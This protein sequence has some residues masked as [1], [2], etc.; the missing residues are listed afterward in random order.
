VNVLRPFGTSL[1]AIVCEKD[2]TLIVLEKH[3]FGNGETLSLQEMLSP[4]DFWQDIMHSYKC[5]FS[6][7]SRQ[8]F[9]SCGRTVYRTLAHGEHPAG[10]TLHIRVYSV[11]CVHPPCTMSARRIHHMKG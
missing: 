9:L 3:I 4:Q 1:A 7:A 2:R 6:R 5:T 11:G 10:M 8:Q